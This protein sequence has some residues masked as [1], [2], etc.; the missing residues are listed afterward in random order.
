MN[1]VRPQL[2][3]ADVSPADADAAQRL[4]NSLTHAIDSFVYAEM[5]SDMSQDAEVRQLREAFRQA[6]DE[7]RETLA[8][9]PGVSA[10]PRSVR[11]A[12]GS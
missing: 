1:G 6:R 9:L 2:S 10:A 4:R 11:P 8:G 7:A 12:S 3:P 5:Y